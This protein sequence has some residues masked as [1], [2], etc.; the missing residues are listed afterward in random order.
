MAGAFVTKISPSGPALV[1]S[2]YLAGSTLDFA[3]KIAVSPGGNAYVTGQTYSSNFPTV[4]PTQASCNSCSSSGSYGT[5]FV[6]EMNVSGSAPVF[7]TFFGGT[8]Y[9]EGVGIAVDPSGNAYVAGDTYSTDFTTT[10]NA[11]Q[12]TSD[13]AGNLNAFMAEFGLTPSTSVAPANL[14]FG[15]QTKG[16]TSASQI[17]TLSD[18][19][20]AQLNITSITTTGDYAQTNTCGTVVGAG[21]NCTISVTFT[22]TATGS[23]TG[24]IVITDN[25]SGNPPQTLGFGLAPELAVGPLPI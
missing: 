15:S 25:A 22:P 12:T 13:A 20:T 11:Y 8:N 1:Y 7:S 6:T 24:T 17:V 21:G 23:R 10:S 19:G 14:N 3:D 16:T 5:V 4:L 18:W 2:S 9:D